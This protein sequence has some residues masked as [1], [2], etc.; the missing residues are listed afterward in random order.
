MKIP[1]VV[2]NKIIVINI[3]YIK[4]YKIFNN[5]KEVLMK[6]LFPDPKFEVMPLNITM[7]CHGTD[8]K[9]VNLWD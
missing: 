6:I 8:H 5:T 4:F 1:K 3:T 7:F 9:T 2:R